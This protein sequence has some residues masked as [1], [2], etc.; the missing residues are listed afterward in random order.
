MI[1]DPGATKMDPIVEGKL[2]GMFLEVENDHEKVRNFLRELGGRL[3]YSSRGRPARRGFHKIEIRDY[4]VLGGHMIQFLEVP[5]RKAEKM[6]M[7]GWTP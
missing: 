4:G 6:I 2:Y 5:T 7:L 1:P 3:I